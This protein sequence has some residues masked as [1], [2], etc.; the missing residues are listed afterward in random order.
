MRSIRA[1]S[2]QLY[3]APR[4]QAETGSMVFQE[5][6]RAL[7]QLSAYAALALKSA[8]QPKAQQAR[9]HLESL[10]NWHRTLPPPMQLSRLSL[11]DPFTMNKAAKRSLLQSH[12]LFL[13]VFIEPYRDCLGQLGEFR[14]RNE[15]MKNDNLGNLIHVEEQCVLAARQSARVASLLQTDGLVR[16]HCWISMCV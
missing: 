7:G 11:V 4:A 13:G 5:R 9:N 10:N 15:P 14:L 16:A 1:D 12:I 6:I 3:H 2:P 8:T